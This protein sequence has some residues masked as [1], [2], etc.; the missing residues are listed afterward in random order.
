MAAQRGS[1]ALYACAL[2]DGT[3]RL[4]DLRMLRPTA[5]A[6][7]AAADGAAVT[8]T[9][10]RPGSHDLAAGTE[11]GRLVLFDTRSLGRPKVAESARAFE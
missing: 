8:A 3:V 7:S 9:A 4:V 2:Q 11:A 1:D 5:F 10:F 6:R